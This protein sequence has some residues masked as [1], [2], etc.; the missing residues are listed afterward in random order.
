MP[1]AD[2][3]NLTPARLTRRADFL[4]C[5]RA[6]W[7]AKPSVVVQ[8]R[9]RGDT[10][11]IL[12]GPRLGFTAS[13]KVGNAVARNRSKRR[14]RE[15]AREVLYPVAKPGFDYVLIARPQTVSVDY[16]R[17]LDDL[18]AALQRLHAPSKA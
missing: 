1:A 2:I 11:D 7:R 18:Q 3:A 14:L 4:A 10:A 9:E 16:T 5:S 12:G 8:L 13:K 6:P 15:A 17:L